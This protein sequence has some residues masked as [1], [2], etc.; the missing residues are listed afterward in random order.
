MEVAVE[1]LQVVLRKRR[2][3]DDI[4][5]LKD[6]GCMRGEDGQED[7]IAIAKIYKIG[8]KVAAVVVEDEKSVIATRFRFRMAVEHLF[9]PGK[10]EVIV[11][12]ACGRVSKENLVFADLYV[13]NPARLNPG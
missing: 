12:P 2:E 3:E 7:S 4:E 9:E 1:F 6:M 11:R 8:G 10:P 13:V 5:R